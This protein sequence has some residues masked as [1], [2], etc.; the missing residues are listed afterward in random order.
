MKKTIVLLRQIFSADR[1]K[2]VIGIGLGALWTVIYW[3]PIP[4]LLQKFEVPE[5]V[6]TLIVIL[7]LGLVVWLLF[8]DKLLMK[9]A[10]LMAWIAISYFIISL[11]LVLFTRGKYIGSIISSVCILVIYVVGYGFREKHK[12]S[13]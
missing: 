10:Q 13:L 12:R 6:F 5:W 8:R 1:K 3:F 9:D 7:F 4:V 2:K 11:M